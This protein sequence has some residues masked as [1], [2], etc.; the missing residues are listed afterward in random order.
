MKIKKGDQVVVIAGDD[1]SSSPHTVTQVVAGGQKML[2]QG[3]NQVY[4]H[5]K[6][7]H[8]KSPA[9]GRLQMEMPIQ[10]SNVMYYCEACQ[11]PTRLGYRYS[12]DGAKVRFCKK[13]D[14]VCS[15]ISPARKKYAK[16]GS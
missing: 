9:G 3:I 2:I 16:S 1:A 4:K 8:P 11:K 10:S 12:D 15:Q 6:R 7:G 5:V 13:C 14:T